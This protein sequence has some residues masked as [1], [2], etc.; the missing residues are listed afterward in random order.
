[1]KDLLVSTPM[2]PTDHLARKAR[3][4][5]LV[6]DDD[7]GIRESYELIFEDSMNIVAAA[8]V[9]GAL[10]AAHD[11]AFDAVLLDIRMPHVSGLEAFEALR[12]AQPRVPIIFVTAI[13]TA[14]TAVHAMRL[15]AFDYVTKPFTVERITAVVSRAVASRVGA[16]HVVGRDIGV[17]AAA[18]VLVSAR[19]MIPATVCPSLVVART[20][21]ADGRSFSDLCGQIAPEAP[22]ISSLVARVATYL[23]THYA[24]VNVEYLAEAIGL[25]PNYLSRVLRDETTMAAKEY[26][27][28]VRIEVAR[29][30]LNTTRDSLEVV[31]DR[32]GLWDASHL[33]RVFRQHVGVTPGALRGEIGISEP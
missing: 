13:D 28:R 8:S 10:A 1:M 12:A 3:P 24:R 5:L 21:Q 29:Y 19:S 18:A 33:T 6:V 31:A 27:T 9:A 15:G 16:V 32:V 11:H 2:S 7:L 20:V 17:A 4:T 23:G 30:L 26:V 22:A 14:E 25:T